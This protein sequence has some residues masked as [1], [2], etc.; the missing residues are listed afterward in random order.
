LDNALP[1]DHIAP[2]NFRRPA[3]EFVFNQED[4]SRLKIDSLKRQQIFPEFLY[5]KKNVDWYKNKREETTLSLN[6]KNR[7]AKKF[8][9]QSFNKSMTEEFDTISENAYLKKDITL[10]IVA[11][12]NDKSRKVRGGDSNDLNS[13]N[14]FEIPDNFDIRLHETCRIMSGWV[15]IIETKD[16]TRKEPQTTD[17]I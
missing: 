17:E 2:V 10:N 8:E 11:V 7:L 15:S 4:L 1:C 12:Q 16:L 13:T 14:T 9:D 6:F 3:N 5:L